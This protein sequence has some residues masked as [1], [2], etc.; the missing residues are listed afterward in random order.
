[1]AQ[2][3]EALRHKP[4]G[5]GFDSR[6]FIDNPSGRTMALGS[7]Q[8]PIEMSTRTISWWIKGDRCVGLITL[9]PSWADCLEISEPQRPE[10]LR[11]CPGL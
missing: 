3:I 1:M 8:P 4:E 5:R 11:A 7:T 10:T 9:P 6:W 2:L